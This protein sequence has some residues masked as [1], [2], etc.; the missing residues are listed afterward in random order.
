[1]GWFKRDAAWERIMDKMRAE[2]RLIEEYTTA[3][4]PA[5]LDGSEAKMK[6]KPR[7]RAVKTLAAHWSVTLRLPCRVRSEANQR[8]HWAER[9]R[10]FAEQRLQMHRVFCWAVLQGWLPPLPLV[11]TFTH[12]GKVM[13]DDN[14]AGAFKGLRDALAVGF[15]VDDGDERIEWRYAQ[16][17]PT[18]GQGVEVK[19]EAKLS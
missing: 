9:R 17:A 15:D 7:K 14:L 12:L 11:V 19:I 5:T 4:V 2:G 3:A 16:R 6:P 13:D 1:M 10:R 18:E 8:C